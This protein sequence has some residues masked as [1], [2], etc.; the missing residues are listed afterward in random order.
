ME[1]PQL[2]IEL[3]IAAVPDLDGPAL[4]AAK[5]AAQLNEIQALKASRKG[6]GGPGRSARL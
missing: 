2:K 5:F 1:R 6:S 3:P 4:V